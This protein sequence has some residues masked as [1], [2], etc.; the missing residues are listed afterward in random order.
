MSSRGETAAS[1]VP[2]IVKIWS[3]PVISNVLAMFVSVLTMTSWPS[4]ERRRLTAPISTPRR[5][6]VEEGRLGQ[7]DDDAR[8]AVLD[9]V[10]ER[11]L[12]LGAVNR[13]I[14]PRTATT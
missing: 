4:R 8:G 7:V 5:G 9:G 14:S 2:R 3:R 12:Q 11:L 6:G 10:L 13:S 1:R